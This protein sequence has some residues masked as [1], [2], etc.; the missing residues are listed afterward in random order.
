MK[1]ITLPA[2]D[3]PHYL[4]R[5]LE[6]LSTLDLSGYTLFVALEP[7][8]PENVDLVRQVSFVG[9]DLRVNPVKLGVQRNP[10]ELIDRAFESGSDWNYHIE[11]DLIFAPDAMDLVNWYRSNRR[12]DV[13]VYGTCN[14]SSTSRGADDN[15]VFLNPTGFSGLGWCLDR[16]GWTEHVRRIW[17]EDAPFSPP[18]QEGWDW[19]LVRYLA[20]G[21]LNEMIPVLCRSTTIGERGTYSTPKSHRMFRSLRLSNG[22]RTDFRL[23]NAEGVSTVRRILE[24]RLR[25]D[26]AK[27]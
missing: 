25:R 23:L 18:H 1:T 21:D 17:F 11:D 19:N 9:V 8:C 26:A 3:R 2:N 20:H 12:D 13:L 4:E 22:T 6:S 16:R 27:A 7:G 14:R 24:R 15:H 5:T 10:F